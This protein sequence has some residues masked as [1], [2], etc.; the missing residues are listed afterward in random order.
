MSKM[1]YF[2]YGPGGSF[3]FNLVLVMKDPPVLGDLE[4]A[5]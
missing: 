3:I 5:I 2:N 4:R 1:L